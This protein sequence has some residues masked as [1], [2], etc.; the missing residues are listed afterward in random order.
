VPRVRL[1][2]FASLRERLGPGEERAVR[3]GTTVG[4]LWEALVRARPDIGAVRVRIA[5]NERYVEGGHELADGDEVAFFPPVS[6]G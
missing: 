1:R 4:S 6:G 5:V 2:F 3:A